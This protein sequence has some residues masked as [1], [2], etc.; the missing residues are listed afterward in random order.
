[1]RRYLVATIAVAVVALFVTPSAAQAVAY[2]ATGHT[3]TAMAGAGYDAQFLVLWAAGG[4]LLL[5]VVLT[6]SI[7][8]ARRNAAAPPQPA[9]RP[10]GWHR[11]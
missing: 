4:A 5:A 6:V 8:I 1:M 3:D 11:A 9:A 7:G 10:A 2:S